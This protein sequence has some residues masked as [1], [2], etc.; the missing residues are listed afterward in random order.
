MK[1]LIIL[2]VVYLLSVVGSYK[3]FQESFSKGGRWGNLD[4]GITEIAITFC[5]GLNTAFALMYTFERISINAN[6][7]FKIQK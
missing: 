3:F 1:K 4:T 7:F 2:I 5:P 6:G